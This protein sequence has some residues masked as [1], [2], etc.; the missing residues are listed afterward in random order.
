MHAKKKI[1]KLFSD[2]QF[3]WWWSTTK[4]PMELPLTNGGYRKELCCEDRGTGV[5]GHIFGCH[6]F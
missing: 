5:V 3:Y 6:L 1:A 4:V 2:L